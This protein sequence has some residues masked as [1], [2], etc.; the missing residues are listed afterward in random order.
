MHP[1]GS[2]IL[3][4]TASGLGYGLLF[5]TGI[6]AAFGLLPTNMWFGILILGLALGTISIGLL[7]STFHLGHPERAWRA[8]TQWRSSWLSR[9]GVMAILVYGPTFYFAAGWVLFD[10]DLHAWRAAGLVMAVGSAITVYCTAMIYA[11]LKSIPRWHNR[12]VAAVYLSLALMSGVMWLVALWAFFL[13]VSPILTFCALLAIGVGFVCK[14]CYWRHIDGADAV[15][16]AE[17]ATGL[18]TTGTTRLLEP[19]HTGRNYLL[20]EMGYQVARKHAA[21]LR[22]LA[23]ILAFA[24]PTVCIL[25]IALSSGAIATVLA[26]LAA[27]SAQLGVTVERW[28]FFAEAEHVVM[29]YYGKDQVRG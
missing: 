9:E 17:S 13:P 6:G 26:V 28:L 22:L 11:S 5:V 19:P 8:V 27:T 12:W 2:I 21:K 1:A 25:A 24:V 7:S 10:Q 23:L 18:G 15:A 14:F 4:T 16:T 29:L 20:E 3:F